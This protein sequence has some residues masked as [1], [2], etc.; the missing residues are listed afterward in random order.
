MNCMGICGG[1][2]GGL[3]TGD[4]RLEV[5]WGMAR[6]EDSPVEWT[7]PYCRDREGEVIKD[8]V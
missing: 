7:S 6:V 8:A 2:S 4:W 5:S 3:E 1:V